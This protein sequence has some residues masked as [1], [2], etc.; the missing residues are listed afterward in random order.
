MLVNDD[1]GEK[2]K[3]ERSGEDGADEKEKS[4]CSIST[5]MVVSRLLED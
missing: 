1:D 2:K 3:E 4:R 5:L